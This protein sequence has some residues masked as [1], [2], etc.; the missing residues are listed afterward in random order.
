MRVV[1]V[2]VGGASCKSRL[3]KLL[4]G[5]LFVLEKLEP[6]RGCYVANKKEMEQSA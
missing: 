2:V 3:V 4:D 1:V 5:F 6:R